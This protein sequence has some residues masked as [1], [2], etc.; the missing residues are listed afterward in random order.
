MPFLGGVAD[1]LFKIGCKFKD[2]VV[3]ELKIAAVEARE[4]GDAV[5]GQEEGLRMIRKTS[6]IY[7]DLLE[8]CRC[9]ASE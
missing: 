3:E 1:D 7:L 8:V 6:K 2:D 9:C 4:D 5:I